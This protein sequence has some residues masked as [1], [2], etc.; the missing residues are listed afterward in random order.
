MSTLASIVKARHGKAGSGNA[1]RVEPIG[2]DTYT[3]W[4]YSTPMLSWRDTG[5]GVDVLHLSTGHGSV[6][7]QNGMNKAFR[8]LG[9]R[10][11]FSRKGGSS[12]ESPDEGCSYITEG[13]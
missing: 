7:D 4:H 12:I 10:Y 3:L 9:I 2:S 1:W 6:S 13:N 5:Y 8:A 11:Y